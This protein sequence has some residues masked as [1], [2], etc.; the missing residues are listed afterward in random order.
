MTARSI[1]KKWPPQDTNSSGKLRTRKIHPTTPTLY[2]CS[3]NHTFLGFR[4]KGIPS[5]RR[6]HAV[7]WCTS[8]TPWT[9]SGR[10][11]RGSPATPPTCSSTPLV[12]IELVVVW[13]IAMLRL[14]GGLCDSVLVQEL[15]KS[16]TV[17]ALSRKWNGI[18]K[19]FTTLIMARSRF[20]TCLFWM[21]WISAFG[22]VCFFVFHGINCYYYVILFV[23]VIVALWLLWICPL[24]A[25]VLWET[26]FWGTRNFLTTSFLMSA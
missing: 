18:S 22:L 19:G 1:W 3:L 12:R 23:T 20:S 11:R 2:K 10:A 13:Y 24:F 15:R 14:D 17:L 6:F 26:D 25:C 16:W 5:A 9:M 8:E 21:L 7:W 4:K